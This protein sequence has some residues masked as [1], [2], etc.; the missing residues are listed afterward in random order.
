VPEDDPARFALDVDGI[1]AAVEA[2]IVRD[3]RVHHI[4]SYLLPADEMGFH[5]GEANSAQALAHLAALARLEQT[6]S[7]GGS[8][9]SYD[10]T[11]AES[12]IADLV[13]AGRTNRDAAAALFVSVETVEVTL[14]TRSW[15]CDRGRNSP[16]ASEPPRNSRETSASP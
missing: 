14:S 16:T 12:R 8:N 10:S 1:R 15:A 3:G 13:A 2:T 6:V 9:L 5:V 11:E 7:A 4:R